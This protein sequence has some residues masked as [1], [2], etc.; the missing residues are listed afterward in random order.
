M[1]GNL[2][3]TSA[4][5][6]SKGASAGSPRRVTK[7]GQTILPRAEPDTEC[8]FC[9]GDSSR[10]RDGRAE[11]ML[12]CWE[13]G[14]AG[15]P[16][17]LGI[18]DFKLFTRMQSYPWL[19]VECKRCEIC[20]EKGNDVSTCLAALGFLSHKLRRRVCTSQ[21]DI[22]FC[23]TCD[24]GWHA[25]CLDPPLAAPP[26]GRFICPTCRKP[27]VF[28]VDEQLPTSR[29]RT[30]SSA[31]LVPASSPPASSSRVATTRS[32]ARSR[33]AASSAQGPA[34]AEAAP[35]SEPF[36]FAALSSSVAGP[37]TALRTRTSVVA[38]TPSTWTPDAPAAIKK[39]IL[40]VPRVHR[41]GGV[42]ASGSAAAATSSIK[43]KG[44]MRQLNSDEE[45]DTVFVDGAED[46]DDVELATDDPATP[47]NEGEDDEPAIEDTLPYGGII[48]GADAEQGDRKPGGE[49]RKRFDAARRAAEK[50]AVQ[51]FIAARDQARERVAQDLERRKAEEAREASKRKKEEEALAK[52]LF[53]VN[54]F[55]SGS[56]AA[57]PN[58]QLET[59]P[60]L[61]VRVS[62]RERVPSA[63][64]TGSPAPS[65]ALSAARA[66]TPVAS[67]SAAGDTSTPAPKSNKSRAASSA[68]LLEQQQQ[69]NGPVTYDTIPVANIQRIR[70]GEYE[71]DTWYQAPY[72]EEIS[73]VPDGTLHIC[74]FCFKYM[75]GAFQAERHKVSC[76]VVVAVLR[77]SGLTSV[78]LLCSSS[79]RRVVLLVTRS[80]VTARSRSLRLTAARTRCAATLISAPRG[81]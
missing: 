36:S 58:E 27:S 63:R 21:D 68:A 57:T 25:S 62:Q 50:D 75:R 42:S 64:A 31:S 32:S 22:M 43:R 6:R 15:H 65:G 49:D 76:L 9:S 20:D 41:T 24:R 81:C 44:K 26:R 45:E 79:A 38:P 78:C 37:S 39:L 2:S 10:N 66:G 59:R 7:G 46:D 5:V 23:D 29:R 67:T 61:A 54:G 17:C 33:L 40:K 34:P 12:A 28:A 73:R 52:E 47:A 4:A 72:P 56:G 16:T 80:T 14:S 51:A 71:I 1:S 19:C 3:R 77:K 55:A 8:A 70:F 69:L 35:A 18:D 74:E 13:C 53:E 48:A 11:P 30:T 60:A